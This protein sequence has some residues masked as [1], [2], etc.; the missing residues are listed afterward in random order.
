MTASEVH[1][2]RFPPEFHADIR[3]AVEIL[4]EGGCTEVH[5]FGSVAEGRIREGSDL[6][7]AVRGCPPDRF[8]ALLGRLLAQLEH[9]VDLVD[10]DRDAR[11]AAFLTKHRL[12]VHV[13]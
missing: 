4:K 5:I 6:D 7:L 13:G 8:F 12:A 3:R 9:T 11:I 1:L 2:E 10:L